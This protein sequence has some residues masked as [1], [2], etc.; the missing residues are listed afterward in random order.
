MLAEANGI[1]RRRS[2]HAVEMSGQPLKLQ[3]QAFTGFLQVNLSDWL[4]TSQQGLKERLPGK[5][6]VKSP[7]HVAYHP[8]TLDP[9]EH[10]F[11]ARVK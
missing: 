11:A 6:F 1:R 8:P 2:F 10:L 3:L 4:A 9:P 7:D 5:R